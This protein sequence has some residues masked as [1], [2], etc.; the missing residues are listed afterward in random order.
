[1]S[2]HFSE[3]ELVFS[4]KAL[5]LSIDNTPSEGIKNQLNFTAAGLER[6]RAFLGFPMEITSGYRS[7]ALNTAVGGSINSQH[8]RGEAAD[9]ICPLFGTP[10]QVCLFLEPARYYLG[11]D[12]LIMEGS[13]VHVSFTLDPRYHVLTKHADGT[14][15]PGL[16]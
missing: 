4:L 7:V 10:E 5:E 16:K 3:H 15:S 8:C 1:M 9:F 13:W 14:Y 11:I 12:Q 2:R 6:I